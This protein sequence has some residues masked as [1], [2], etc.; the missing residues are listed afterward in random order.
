MC[1]WNN[2]APVC[3]WTD[4]QTNFNNN[5]FMVICVVF[6]IDNTLKEVYQDI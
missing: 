4:R 6:H 5:M 1:P 2:D 3:R